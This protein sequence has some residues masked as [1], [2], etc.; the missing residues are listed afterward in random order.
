M[1]T[2]GYI[3]EWCGKTYVGAK[4]K[5]RNYQGPQVCVYTENG[6]WLRIV[7]NPYDNSLMV[8]LEAAPFLI[9][10]IQKAMRKAAKK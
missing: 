10:A 4:D 7:E 5:D 9:K 8:N 2:E 1:A 6:T 3:T